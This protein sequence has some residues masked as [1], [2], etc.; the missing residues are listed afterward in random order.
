[1]LILGHPKAQMTNLT[2]KECCIY[3]IHME[4]DNGELGIH[5]SSILYRK[6]SFYHIMALEEVYS[7]HSYTT[8]MPSLDL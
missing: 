2:G 7:L 1:M 6:S 5:P 4:V 8:F 3:A